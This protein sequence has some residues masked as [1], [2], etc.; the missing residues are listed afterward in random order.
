MSKEEFVTSMAYV[1]FPSNSGEEEKPTDTENTQAKGLE[2]L[3]VLPSASW[4]GPWT[5][6]NRILGV[7]SCLDVPF[8]IAFHPFSYFGAWCAW[9]ICGMNQRPKMAF[10]SSSQCPQ[11]V[12][13][14]TIH[15]RMQISSIRYLTFNCVV[16]LLQLM[17]VILCFFK[18]FYNRHGVLI[19]S[20]SQVTIS[21]APQ[22]VSRSHVADAAS[23]EQVHSCCVC[24]SKDID[25]QTCCG[26]FA[27]PQ[28]RRQYL[29]SGFFLDFIATPPL[30]IMMWLT[31]PTTYPPPHH[32]LLNP[33]V[34]SKL[35]VTRFLLVLRFFAWQKKQLSASGDRTLS[36]VLYSMMPVLV[37][38]LHT[39]ACFW[40]MV[41]SYRMWREYEDEYD[42]EPPCLVDALLS[43]S[44][45]CS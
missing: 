29:S 5:T 21:A 2:R 26:G 43:D 22:P 39:S 23:N 45:F 14:H 12:R 36:M 38:L 44:L 4:L 24:N 8:R 32:G 17:D 6:L 19:T 16:E 25:F 18:A 40:W 9:L 27:F 3:V 7:Y 13:L 11:P 30:D 31:Y 35:R 20:P 10:A 42:G 28:I 15:L 33:R 1:L 37:V 34:T 41:G